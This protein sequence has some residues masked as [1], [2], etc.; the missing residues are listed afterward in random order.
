M[1]TRI[2]HLILP[3]ADLDAAAAAFERLGLVLTPRT[4]HAGLGTA[5]R[6]AFV[7]PDAARF[8]YLELLAIED[9][10]LLPASRRHY[11]ETLERGGGLASV[12]FAPADLDAALARLAAAGADIDRSA[13]R[14][15]DG[16]ILV[17]AAVV[18][19]LP[20]A[21][22]PVLLVNYPGGFV[23]R[24]ERSRSLGRFAHTFPLRRLDHL[25]VLAP[26]L[27]AATRTWADLLGLQVVGEI[28]TPAL[29]IR[30]LRCGDAIVELLAPAGPGSPLADRPPALLPVTA[31]EVDG[32]L[33][34][35]AA[36][37]RERGFTCPPPEPGVIPGTLRTTIPAVELA[38]LAMQLL[39]YVARP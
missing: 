15:D 16:R 2:D 19:G 31:W 1:L 3:V 21:P 9:P 13:V 26:D 37:A 25:A 8:V 6:A 30:Q 34:T 35:A 29:V 14:A 10:A 28:T 18:R 27:E 20:A 11:R 36:L 24:F 32:S 23:A 17:D 39:E 22:F 33:E 12:A 7:G 38:G 4:A 5:N